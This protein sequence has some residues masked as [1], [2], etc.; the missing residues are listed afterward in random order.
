MN[1]VQ[2]S[3]TLRSACD[4]STDPASALRGAVAA[5]RAAERAATLIE[6]TAAGT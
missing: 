4:S 2:I 1:V 6:G 5:V 3:T